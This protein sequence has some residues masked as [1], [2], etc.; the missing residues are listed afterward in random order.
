MVPRGRFNT[1]G[2]ACALA[3]ARSP[4]RPRP[5]AGA[6]ASAPRPMSVYLQLPEVSANLQ[7]KAEPSMS[8]ASS[9]SGTQGTSKPVG[10]AWPDFRGE[11]GVRVAF[12]R[13]QGIIQG[14][15]RPKCHE[16]ETGGPMMS[17]SFP[18]LHANGQERHQRTN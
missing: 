12:G 16:K 8:N 10:M 15:W 17:C 5:P 13:R 3:G 4:L 14:G 6:S 11:G 1:R 2:G 18:A 7:I 9:G